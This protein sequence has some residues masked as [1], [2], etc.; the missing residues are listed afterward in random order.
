VSWIQ[1]AIVELS[2]TLEGKNEDYR[3][4]GEFSNFEFAANIAGVT[5]D[6][7]MLTQIAIK[8]GRLMG[9]RDDP[10]NESYEDSVKDLA[11][12]ALILYGYLLSNRPGPEDTTLTD[13]LFGYP[14]NL[15]ETS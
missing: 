9:L 1:K 3:I 8:I 7:V 11:G 14:R 15:D 6:E 10:N 2:D 4:D 13:S 12:Y 5:T